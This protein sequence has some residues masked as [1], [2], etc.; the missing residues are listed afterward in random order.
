MSKCKHVSFIQA[1]DGINRC[2]ECNLSEWSVICELQSELT[3]LQAENAALIETQRWISVSE[4]LPEKRGVYL[5]LEPSATPS[6][7]LI[8]ECIPNSLYD[9]NGSNITHW[10]PL[11]RAPLPATAKEEAP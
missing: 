8:Y 4:G 11:P 10:M 9:W 3:R 2:S 6:G 5:C 7:Y 1:T